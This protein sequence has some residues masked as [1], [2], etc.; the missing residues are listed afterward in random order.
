MSSIILARFVGRSCVA[1]KTFSRRLANPKLPICASVTLAKTVW[2]CQCLELGIFLKTRFNLGATT[3]E[4]IENVFYFRF[5]GTRII[6]LGIHQ[7]ACAYAKSMQIRK[8]SFSAGGSLL[9]FSNR[10][11]TTA[12]TDFTSSGFIVVTT[13]RNSDSAILVI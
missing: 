8:D 9:L 12:A 3:T 6:N 4:P 2:F 13:D 11:C 7:V 5:P 1:I 10:L